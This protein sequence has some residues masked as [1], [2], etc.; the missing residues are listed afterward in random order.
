VSGNVTGHTKEHWQTSFANE[1]GRLAQGVGTRMPSGT[2]TILFIKKSEI[3]VGRKATHGKLVCMVRPQKNET[4]RT[5]LTV[6]GDQINYPGDVSTPTADIVTAKLL[7]NS[8]ISTP[9]AA[10]ICAD[11][12]DFY[13]ET[14]MER[15]EY[16]HIP[17]QL[18]PPE[19]IQ[20][21]KLDALVDNGN[22]YIE[23]RKGMYGLP[24]AGIIA[25]KKLQKHLEKYGYT[26]TPNTPVAFGSITHTPSLSPS[27]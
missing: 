7:I 17:Y 8:V 6:G 10:F 5:R 13:L 19:I 9:G 14:E 12:S 21:Y 1:L 15:Y 4:H 20:Q 16:I 24:P 2:N 18:I 26:P 3:P 11:I 25:N 23:I 27:L 22:I